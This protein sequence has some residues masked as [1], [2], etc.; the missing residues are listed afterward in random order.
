MLLPFVQFFFVVDYFPFLDQKKKHIENVSLNMDF[1][2]DK[3]K[4]TLMW[5]LLRKG[6]NFIDEARFVSIP[7]LL[8]HY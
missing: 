5:W 8:N 7:H 4:I 2:R 1:E 3:I 6:R